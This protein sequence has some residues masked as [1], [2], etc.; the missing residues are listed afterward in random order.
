MKMDSAQVSDV[1]KAKTQL[2][3][4]MRAKYAGL[5]ETLNKALQDSMR[6]GALKGLSGFWFDI[7]RPDLAGTFAEKV[8]ELTQG[9]A[10]AEAWIAAGEVYKAGIADLTDQDARKYC[11][12]AAMKCFDHALQLNADDVKS[13]INKALCAVELP[14]EAQ[15]MAG[16][17]MLRSLSDKYPDNVAVLNTLGELALKTG[18]KEKALQRLEKAIAIEPGNRKTICLLADAYQMSGETDKATLYKNRCAVVQ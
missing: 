14:D 18:Q 5:E 3:D 11:K 16:I 10:K 7:S 2:S 13:A 1:E 6:I 17:M 12:T 8:A 15:P 4:S 9:A